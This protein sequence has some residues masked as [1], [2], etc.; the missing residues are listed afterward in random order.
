[1]KKPEGDI[2]AKW[3]NIARHRSGTESDGGVLAQSKDLR[4]E[5]E[6]RAGK[7]KGG[8]IYRCGKVHGRGWIATP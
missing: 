3:T 4:K 6:K 1:M 7:K 5:G 8:K 2:G